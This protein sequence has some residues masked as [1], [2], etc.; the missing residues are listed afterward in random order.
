MAKVSG[1]VYCDQ[2]SAT[3]LNEK[4]VPSVILPL[5]SIPVSVLPTEKSF[6]LCLC[7]SDIDSNND[8]E[9]QIVI[10]HNGERIIDMGKSRVEKD[11]LQNEII[12]NADIRNLKIRET[13]EICT[14]VFFDDQVIGEFPIMV[15]LLGDT[16]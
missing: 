15:R 2:A 9:L 12:L 13:G 8:H 14:R 6:A 4:L 3:M 11:K 10:D 1:F 7:I 5:P 16:V